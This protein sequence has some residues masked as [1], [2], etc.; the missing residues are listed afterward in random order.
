M[1]KG[2]IFDL[3]GVLVDTAKYHFAAW[4]K[5]AQEYNFDLSEK[6][7][8]ELKGVG[9]RESLL[10][11]MEWGQITMS[12]EEMTHNMERKNAWYLDMISH[13]QPS[14]YLPGAKEFLEEA[15]HLKLKIG[16][17]SASKNALPILENLNFT[18]Y[19]DSIVDG[20]LITRS[21]PD[22]QVFQLGAEKLQLKPEC[23]VVFEDALAGVE[24]ARKGGFF[25][26]GIGP[27]KTLK[28][29]HFCTPSLAQISP[30]EIL[31]QLN[32]HKL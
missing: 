2:F 3:D 20:N 30:A 7:N 14:D 22:P 19:F 28:N 18:A 1:I 29:A 16:L 11:I 5:L 24:A 6:K 10:K 13:M 17:G 12:E 15:R 27:P 32:L 8:E 31:N 23:I 4:K 9:R 21:K 26:V 25:C